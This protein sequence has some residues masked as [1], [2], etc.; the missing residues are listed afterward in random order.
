MIAAQAGFVVGLTGGIGSGKSSVANLFA[1]RGVSVI[2]ADS[3]A[4]RITASDGVAIPA[5]RATFGLDYLDAS[6][7]LDRAKMRALVFSDAAAKKTLEAI[8]HPLIGAA[9]RQALAA[10]LAS[11]SAYA[12]LMIPLLVETGDPHARCDRVLVV[13]LPEAAQLERVM[14]RDGLPRSL[15]HA[16]M[17]AQ[18]TRAERLRHADDVIDNSGAPSLLAPQVDELHR[19]YVLIAASTRTS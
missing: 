12:M 15:V 18:A 4:H 7:A 10:A 16:I 2:D 1:E 17:A 8:L 13:D 3:I 9:T 11:T 5:I 14:Q 19:R 6:G